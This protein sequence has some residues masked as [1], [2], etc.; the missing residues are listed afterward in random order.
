M[1][2]EKNLSEISQKYVRFFF[3]TLY[4][5]GSIFEIKNS[6]LFHFGDYFLVPKTPG[7]SD[8]QNVCQELVMLNYIKWP[9]KYLWTK[10]MPGIGFI[11]KSI[12]QDQVCWYQVSALW[13]WTKHMPGIGFIDKSVCQ[14]QVMLISSVSIVIMNKTYARDRF[15]WQKVCQK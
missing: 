8:W 12:C 15:C 9:A 11:D 13:L 6:L 2:F 10:H 14:D 4:I 1:R 7:F 5:V 3:S